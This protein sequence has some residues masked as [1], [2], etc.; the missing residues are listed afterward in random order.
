MTA[1]P[2]TAPDVAVTI[3]GDSSESTPLILRSPLSLGAGPS[4]SAISDGNDDDECKIAIS[5]FEG[6]QETSTHSRWGVLCDELGKLVNLAVPVVGTFLLEIIPGV[7]SIVL[8]GHVRGN[9][10]E[11]YLDAAALS[12]MYMNVMAMSIGIGLSS[13]LDTLCSQAYGANETKRMGTYLQT[14]MIVLAAFFAV[15]C[16]L[17]Y[18]CAD[19]LIALGQPETVSQLAGTFTLYLLPGIPFLFAYE[20][21]RRVLQAQNVAAPMFFVAV[22][23]NLINVGLGYYL[24]YHSGWGW[25]G[26]SVART[27]C[28]VSFFV[29]LLPYTVWSGLAETFWTGLRL[30]EA[31]AGIPNFLALGVPG[32]LQLCF[33]WWAFEVISLM[34]G[35]LPEAVVAIGSNAVIMNIS[36]TVFMLYLGLSISCS[37]RVGN[38]L[39]A[40]DGTRASLA[41]WLTIGMC[42][43]A[44]LFCAAF[45]LAFREDLPR[46]FTHD[47]EIN[48]LASTLLCVC[49]VFQIPDAING[50]VQ[51]ILRGSGRQTLG[52]KLNFVAYYLL[53]IPLVA[54]L[55]LG[56]GTW[57]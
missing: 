31:V 20:L 36:S 57:V 34:C 30:R 47:E 15:V 51:G 35:L 4:T 44:A 41:A 45:L 18:R 29:M 49:A 16:V 25:L 37:V 24:V 55:H 3:A 32:M 10:T 21:L 2:L 27:A 6:L 46:L 5:G 40:G 48:A 22:A 39:G 12:N 1:Q 28:N 43:A 26:A 14:G 8:V 50:A 23:A 19:V 11:E 33:E 54:Q 53:G 52:A 7:V 38:A 17:F 9:M 13:A 56:G 42:A